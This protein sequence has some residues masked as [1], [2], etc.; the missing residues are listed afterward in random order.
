MAW[1]TFSDVT[2]RWAGS[3]APSDEDL[4]NALIQ[5][6]EAVILVEFPRI[7]DRIDAGTLPLNVVTMVVCRMVSRVLRNP[8]NL[9]YLQQQTGP[10]GQ[11]Q[12]FGTGA[13]DIWL[14]EEE[15]EMLAPKKRGKAYQVDLAPNAT[16][17]GAYVWLSGNG[18]SEGFQQYGHGY[19]V[20]QED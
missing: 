17:G 12:N 3:N 20:D 15:E 7:Q 11:S 5:D 1:A 19:N 6:A 8:G 14:S 16:N 13:V 10:F 18:Y 2:D 9:T 4:V